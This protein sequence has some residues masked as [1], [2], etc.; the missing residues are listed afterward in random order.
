MGAP[1]FPRRPLADKFSY[2]ALVRVNAYKCAKFQL[3]SCTSVRDK[4]G[5][6]LPPC[7]TPYAE[8]FVCAQST[9]QGQTACQFQHHISMHHAVMRI[10]IS[11]RLTI[12]CAQ[13]WFFLGGFEGEDVKILC[14]DSQKALLCVN[15]RLLVYRMSKSVQRPEL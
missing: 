14:S 15:T 4:E 9:W 7:R 6:L 12:I 3:P 2:R 13:K 8:T 11:H 10:C 5:V 1:G